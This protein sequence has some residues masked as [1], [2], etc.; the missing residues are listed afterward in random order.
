MEISLQ[1][2]I[3][4]IDATGIFIEYTQNNKQMFKSDLVAYNT[5]VFFVNALR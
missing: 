1:C 2:R 4:R 5:R 3:Y